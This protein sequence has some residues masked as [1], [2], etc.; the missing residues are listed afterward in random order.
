MKKVFAIAAIAALMT[1]CNNSSEKKEKDA[2]K[3]IDAMIDSAGKG[4]DKM[5][6][7]AGK[8]LDKMADSAGKELEKMSDTATKKMEEVKTKM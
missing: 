5:M 7:S 6:D 8:E 4:M 3:E 1:S 2:M